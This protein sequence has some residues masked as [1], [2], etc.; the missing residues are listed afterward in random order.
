MHSERCSQ[1]PTAQQLAQLNIVVDKMHFKGHVDPWC[2]KHCNPYEHKELD[3]A[4]AAA[5]STSTK[6]KILHSTSV[7]YRL[8]LKCVSRYSP[9]S[10]DTQESHST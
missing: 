10:R 9:G 2:K 7:L 4:S 5:A 6:K 3:K 1:T 8:I